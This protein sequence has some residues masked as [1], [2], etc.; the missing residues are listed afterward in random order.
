MKNMQL[1]RPDIKADIQSSG[2]GYRVTL[3]SAELA[4][5]VYLS[6]GDND[7]TFSDNYVDLLPGQTVQ[8]EVNSKAGIEQLKQ[9]MKIVSLYDAFLPPMQVSQTAG[10]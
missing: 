3:Q 5:D 10:H 7:A 6:F 4:R 1:P 9:A 2:S 8:I